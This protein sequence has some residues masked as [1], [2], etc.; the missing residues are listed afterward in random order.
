[1]CILP[2]KRDSHFDDPFHLVKWQLPNVWWGMWSCTGRM[3]TRQHHHFIFLIHATQCKTWMQFRKTR[4]HYLSSLYLLF[5]S[6]TITNVQNRIKNL[7]AQFLP[8]KH[9]R[10]RLPLIWNQKEWLSFRPFCHY[11][12]P[13]HFTNDNSHL[14]TFFYFLMI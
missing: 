3:A 2:F 13:C 8:P 10:N 9:V 7:K 14:M 4:N 6:K 11:Y 12:H 5:S 1:M